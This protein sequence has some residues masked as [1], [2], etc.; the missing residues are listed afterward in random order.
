MRSLTATLAMVALFASANAATINVPGEQP[1][2]QNAIDIAV[3]Y[4][5]VLVAPGT[6]L[7][8]IDFHGK[9]IVSLLSSGGAEQTIIRPL[10]T[11]LPAVRL[12]SGEFACTLQGFTFSGNGPSN[13]NLIEV[14]NGADVR[15]RS[16]IF[17]DFAKDDNTNA[18]IDL[19]ADLRLNYNLFCN[20][21]TCILVSGSDT[22]SSIASNTF[23]DCVFGVIS[24]SENRPSVSH[25]IFSNISSVAVNGFCY[26]L[27][28]NCFW[29]NNVDHL[30]GGIW[31]PH[32]VIEDPLYIDEATG[33][34]NLQDNSICI[35][36]EAGAYSYEKV[37][38]TISSLNY[39]TTTLDQYVADSILLF[40]W[41]Y[42]DADSV[43][44]VQYEIEVGT[45]ADWNN[46]ELWSSGQVSS[47]ETHAIYECA[48]LDDLTRYYWRIR[49]N[50]GSNWGSWM[51][52]WFITSFRSSFLVPLEYST[53]QE[54]INLTTAGDTVFVASGHYSENISTYRKSVVLLGEDAR[55]TIISPRR[56]DYPALMINGGSDSLIKISGFTFSGGTG[57]ELVLS[58]SWF[59]PE[60]SNNVFTAFSGQD[61][62]DA[63]LEIQG[64]ALVKNNLFYDNSGTNCILNY[65]TSP[66]H[67]INNTFNSNQQGIYSVTSNYQAI[68]KNNIFSSMNDFVILGA[69]E[70]LD[71]NCMWNNT[72]NYGG[73]VYAGEHSIFADPVYADPT[74]L[75]FTLQDNSPCINSGDP[76]PQYF[77]PDNTRNDMGAFPTSAEY[78]LPVYINFGQ[79]IGNITVVSLTPTIFWSYFDTVAT[80][81]AFYELQV[82]TDDDWS[83]AE[84]WA[85]E[86]VSSSDTSAIYSGVTLEDRTMYFVRVRLHN[87]THWGDWI[88]SNFRTH[89]QSA[90]VV[91]DD[92]PTIQSAVD[93][94]LDGDTIFVLPGI[95]YENVSFRGEDVVLASNYIL[96]S[97]SADI[98]NTIIDGSQLSQGDSLGSVIRIYMG[99][100]IS[101]KIIGFTIQNGKG[102][103]FGIQSYMGRSGGGFFV[104][105]SGV[106]I[107]NNIIKD[108]SAAAPNYSKG[109]GI[110]LINSPAVI[111]DNQIE[112]NISEGRNYGYG[113]G[114]YST[115]LEEL[116]IRNNTIINCVGNGISLFGSNG[117][118]DHNII[119][120]NEGH[121]MW[122]QSKDPVVSNNFIHDN[123]EYGIAVNY[124]F[125]Y[126]DTNVIVNNGGGISSRASGMDVVNNTIVGNNGPA[127]R[128]FWHNNVDIAF[129]NNIVWD[130]NVSGDQILLEESVTLTA[131]FND[132]QGGQDNVFIG[133]SVV[134]AWGSGNILSDPLFCDAPD[135]NYSLHE[136]S[137][138]V[139]AGSD[140]NNMGAFD[141]VGCESD[142]GCCLGRVGD[143]NGEGGDEPTIGDIALLVD[144]LFIGLSVDELP[145]LAE[146]DVN[147]SGGADPTCDDISIGDVAILIDYLFISQAPALLGDCQ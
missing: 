46:A 4:D 106:S 12:V 3:Q 37:Y 52:T 61:D 53:I 97:D 66:T 74:G 41:S 25:N 5:T 68:V 95:Y 147:L 44:Q 38:P 63:V 55:S 138:C 1:T 67:I 80:T 28:R 116:V 75:D 51:P 64:C 73:G 49:I 91:P 85:T 122:A 76:A 104:D 112:N 48:P 88:Q 129:E 135:D 7:E 78:P 99:E 118:I 9:D 57:G 128:K 56:E 15:L 141:I 58:A 70:E 77:D 119:A 103:A 33:N 32:N 31:G 72:A 137:P 89:I 62:Q 84:L 45:D 27:D 113:G 110:C 142:N 21:G 30:G 18:V 69:V 50:D 54:A 123:T 90:L 125:L 120:Y 114:I 111:E 23:D 133:E 132:I 35:Y 42:L 108:N 10:N 109:G 139:G 117:V 14:H 65:S 71:Y 19:R 93:I 121:G 13:A 105:H 96:T 11:Y 101:T 126:I 102:V 59:Y 127:L 26:W 130:N 34:Y 115:G 60:I 92:F 146:A 2:I 43:N 82:G 6:Y 144:A 86:S 29:N 83:E 107:S 22:W 24:D 143:I 98:Q 16:N 100:T 79:G 39:G 94:A 145:C 124:G 40:G 8:N 131:S 134:L 81:Q 136:N 36:E 20:S 140:S 87:G 47:S 17:R